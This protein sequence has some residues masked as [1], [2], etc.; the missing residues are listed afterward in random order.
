MRRCFDIGEVVGCGGCRLCCSC[1]GMIV[2]WR[3]FLGARSVG[4]VSGSSFEGW[5]VGAGGGKRGGDG[6]CVDVMDVVAVEDES[7][8]MD[9]R[10]V[11]Q[12]I[13]N[14]FQA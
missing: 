1:S 8:G 4:L 2:R 13:I 6:H 5:V 11:L 9:E 10:V 14:S 7:R 12:F 3:V